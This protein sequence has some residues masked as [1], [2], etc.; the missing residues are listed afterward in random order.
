M[1]LSVRSRKQRTWERLELLFIPVSAVALLS[2][3]AL[4]R[5]RACE[6]PGSLARSRPSIEVPN[7]GSLLIASFLGGGAPWSAL[8][9]LSRSRSSSL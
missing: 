6:G 5:E 9:D 7:R 4:I 2:S 1:A 8:H 3:A